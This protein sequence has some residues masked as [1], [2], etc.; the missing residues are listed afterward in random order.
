LQYRFDDRIIF[1]LSADHFLN[2]GEWEITVRNDEG[3]DCELYNFKVRSQLPDTGVEICKEEELVGF[4]HFNDVDCNLIDP[5]YLMY[6]QDANIQL[7]S[8]QLSYS[9]NLDDSVLDNLTG[10]LWKKCTAGETGDS[11]TAGTALDLNWQQGQDYCSALPSGP[12]GPWR[13]PT[14]VDL[15]HL[16]H[17]DAGNNAA[18]IDSGAFPSTPAK[19]FWTSTADSLRQDDRWSI[20]FDSGML[21]TESKIQN[22]HVRCVSGVSPDL[23]QINTLVNLGDQIIVQENAGVMWSADE[24]VA[25][26]FEGM[27]YCSDLTWAGYNDWRLPDVKELSLLVDHTELFPAAQD[28]LMSNSYYWSTTHQ[29][30]SS[31]FI[32]GF[33][34]SF[35][36]GTSEFFKDDTHYAKCVRDMETTW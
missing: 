9:V 6:D 11:C 23:S 26:Y 12:A 28:D 30:Y 36:N 27:T 19:R 4:W 34:F 35:G 31:W 14:A 3:Y 10:L 13:L 7:A 1:E 29:P 8:R 21:E 32:Y 15:Y 25:T 22:A 5:D 20:L 17:F 2:A 16:L 18:F 33:N 24:Q